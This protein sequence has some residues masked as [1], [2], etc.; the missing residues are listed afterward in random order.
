[1]ASKERL[2]PMYSAVIKQTIGE[3]QI[4]WMMIMK[5]MNEW[6][7]LIELPEYLT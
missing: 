6:M 3:M 1:M 7:Y 4:V 2:S 5:G